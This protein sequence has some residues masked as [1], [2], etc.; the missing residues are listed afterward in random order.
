MTEVVVVP[1]EGTEEDQADELDAARSAGA[2]EVH[3]EHAE[4]AAA[5]AE[6]AADLAASAVGTVDDVAQRAEAAA[7]LATVAAADATTA[8]DQILAA[9]AEQNA[10][11]ASL[12]QEVKTAQQPVPPPSDDKPSTGKSDRPP[13]KRA[14]SG[15]SRL[16]FGDR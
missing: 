16:Y 2:A 6:A 5:E 4:A 7:E 1:D 13:A 8:R 15:I 10:A 3:E 11:V 9:I 14:R 12:V